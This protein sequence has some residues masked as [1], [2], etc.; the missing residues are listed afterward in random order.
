MVVRGQFLERSTV[1]PSGELYLDGL[2]HRGALGPALLI[3]P[4]HPSRGGSMDSA[5][6]AELAFAASHAGHAT[7]RFNYRGVGASQG[8][9]GDFASF[10]E[11]GRAALLTLQE[12]SPGLGVVI[13]GFDLG[14]EVAVELAQGAAVEGVVVIG[15]V[16]K[17]YD[18]TALSRL[19]MKALVV[20][21]EEDHG[22]DRLAL[23]ELCQSMGDGL[24]VI[25]EADHVF[26]Q[27]L[28]ELGRVVAQFLGG[29]GARVLPVEEE[30]AGRDAVVREFDLD[31]G[32]D[33]EPDLDI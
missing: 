2:S 32:P 12:N 28:T 7:L 27:G 19:R 11:D 17:A 16:S 5:V 30:D 24:V 21:G 13:A 23:A 20:V 10:V 3:C 26:S 22:A 6:C 1:I 31:P 9:L 18:F 33:D 14:A 4:P 29:E 8:Q 25:P 15:P